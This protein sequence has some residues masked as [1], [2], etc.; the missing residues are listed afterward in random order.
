M[1][2]TRGLLPSRE[3][4]QDLGVL[5]ALY[6]TFGELLPFANTTWTGH[7]SGLDKLYTAFAKNRLRLTGRCSDDR[8][9]VGSK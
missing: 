4:A 3:S 5:S 2:E 7:K 8:S 9:V 6:S 1:A